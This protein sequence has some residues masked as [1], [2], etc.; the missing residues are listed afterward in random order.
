VKT[1]RWVGNEPE[2]LDVTDEV[3]YVR[4]RPNKG[5]GLMPGDIGPPIGG[6]CGVGVV[7]GGVFFWPWA[8]S[9]KRNS[10]NR[11]ENDCCTRLAEDLAPT[12]TAT[13]LVILVLL[14]LRPPLA[15]AW[16]LAILPPRRGPFLSAR[17]RRSPD[18]LQ[19]CFFPF[20]IFP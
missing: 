19:P 11:S 16:Y 7:V 9:F 20:G 6:D 15:R 12:M 2:T 17:R 13:H 10:T 14:F 5:F 18:T 3:E 4:C 1:G 8:A